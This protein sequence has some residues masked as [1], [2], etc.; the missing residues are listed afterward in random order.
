MYPFFK[1]NFIQK[2]KMFS[3]FDSLL[4]K[5]LFSFKKTSTFINNFSGKAY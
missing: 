3:V 1:I 5:G 2:M 4:N